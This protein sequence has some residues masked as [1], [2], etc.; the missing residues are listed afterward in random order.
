[1]HLTVDVDAADEDQAADVSWRRAEDYLQTVIGDH[2]AVSAEASLDGIGADDVS[3]VPDVARP[4][5]GGG[6]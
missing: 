6:S 4:L 5:K 2:D 1:V 3:E